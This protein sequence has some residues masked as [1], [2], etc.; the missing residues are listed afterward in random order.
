[1][2]RA[3]VEYTAMNGSKLEFKKNGESEYTR[4][5]GLSN[6]P[7]LGGTPNKI[8]TTDLDNEKYET[9]IMG[10]M[11]ALELDFEFNMEDPSAT[12]NIKLASDLEDEDSVIEFKLT[13]KNG[14]TAEFQSKVRTT[15]LGGAN[16]DLQKFTMH[17]APESE[18]VITIPEK[19][20]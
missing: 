4:I 7:D 13:Y 6:I 5:Y 2:A 9:N 14:I 8:D 16:G 19:T 15:I 11:P 3:G 10:L 12:A 20:L 17:L 18:P 1:M